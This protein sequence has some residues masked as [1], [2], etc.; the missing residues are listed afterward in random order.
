MYCG[1]FK[2]YILNIDHNIC[3]RVNWVLDILLKSPNVE[4]PIEMLKE[5]LNN[6]NV[7]R[8]KINEYIKKRKREGK[9]KDKDAPPNKKFKN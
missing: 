1:T 7:E 6:A 2:N 3:D 9:D 5:T 4:D 8:N